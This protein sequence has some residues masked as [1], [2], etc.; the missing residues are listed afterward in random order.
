MKEENVQIIPTSTTTD[1]MGYMIEVSADGVTERLM[2]TK[3]ELEKIVLYGQGV[4]K[5][6]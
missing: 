2:V 5:V 4:L 3:E 1:K 6:K